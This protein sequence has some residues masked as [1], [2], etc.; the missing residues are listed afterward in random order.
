M[1][2]FLGDQVSVVCLV[3]HGMFIFLVL[4][5]IFSVIFANPLCT[6]GHSQAGLSAQHE[7][8][9]F[10]AGIFGDPCRAFSLLS[11]APSPQG[12]G[13]WPWATAATEQWALSVLQL[14]Q[15]KSCY[16]VLK[17]KP[18]FYWRTCKWYNKDLDWYL[19]LRWLL[20]SCIT[21]FLP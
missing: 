12:M 17:N 11:G 10:P 1:W 5:G 14:S 19:T 13:N 21:A 16:A 3:T 6:A 15:V 4:K 9:F 7:M 18:A 8:L 2:Q 20:R